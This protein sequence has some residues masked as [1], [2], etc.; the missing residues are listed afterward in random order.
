MVIIV[1]IIPAKHQHVGMPTLAFSSVAYSFAEQLARRL[2]LG[3]CIKNETRV[4]FERR[5]SVLSVQSTPTPTPAATVLRTSCLSAQLLR[6]NCLSPGWLT[7]EI[8]WTKSIFMYSP[9]EEIRTVF[10]YWFTDFV[11]QRGLDGYI[12]WN[13]QGCSRHSHVCSLQ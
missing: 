2:S 10:I 9:R 11:S 5:W 3:I 8:N 1:N 4:G 7:V 13:W 12:W 6:P